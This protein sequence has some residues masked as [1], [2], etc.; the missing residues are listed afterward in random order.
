MT[1]KIISE[2]C[3]AVMSESPIELLRGR[4]SEIDKYIKLLELASMKYHI[5]P[6]WPY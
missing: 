5:E 4:A 2:R 3:G 6:E 1:E